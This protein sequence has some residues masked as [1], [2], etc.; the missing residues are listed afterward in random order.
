MKKVMSICL[1]MIMAVVMSVNAFAASGS[2][3]SSPTAT[4]A[5]GLVS[6]EVSEEGASVQLTIVPYSQKQDLPEELNAAFEAAYNEIM[7]AENL[8]ALTPELEEVAAKLGVNP[9]NLA[10][11]ELFDIHVSSETGVNGS[12]EYTI[13]LESDT[14]NHFVALLHRDQND[15]WEV[16]ENAEVVDDGK[17]LKFTIDNFSPFAIVVDTGAVGQETPKTGITDTVIYVCAGIMAVSAV[18][19]FLIAN[20]RK[21]QSV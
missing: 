3:V 18:A 11:S 2:F 6:V 21:K 4:P 9:E 14:L 5:P 17:N 15:G 13:A 1:M 20:K 7:E 10:V 12:V 16:V 8:T 19:V